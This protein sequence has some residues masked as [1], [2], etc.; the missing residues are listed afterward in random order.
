MTDAVEA[1]AARSLR[2][3]ADYRTGLMIAFLAA[4]PLRLRT[5]RDLRIGRHIVRHENGYMIYL[6]PED[7]KTRRPLE[8]PLPGTLTAAVDRYV[9]EMRPVLLQGCAPTD[10]LWVSV[11]GTA[12]ASVTIY[13]IVRETTEKALGVPM[14]PHLFRD[15]LATSLAVDAPE[16]VGASTT[17]LGHGSTRT[18]AKHYNQAK[19]IDAARRYQAAILDLRR[20]TGSRRT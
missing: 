20:S 4:R 10:K 7:Q 19:G 17:L 18:A 8:A 15:A 3:A 9:A 5:F 14:N 13:G 16:D 6:G 1:G 12:L 2:R 11:A